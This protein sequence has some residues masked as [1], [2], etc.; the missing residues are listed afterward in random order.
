MAITEPTL[1]I[2][3]GWPGYAITPQG[4]QCPACQRVYS[5]SMVMC[6]Y[7]PAEPVT[8]TGSGTAPGC[9]CGTPIPC[10]WHLPPTTVTTTNHQGT[11]KG[12]VGGPCPKPRA[13]GLC[14]CNEDDDDEPQDCLKMHCDH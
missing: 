12:H 4:W 14:G 6:S 10:A 3:F 9:S 7:C 1:G 11:V 8:T 2:P 5:P 13:G